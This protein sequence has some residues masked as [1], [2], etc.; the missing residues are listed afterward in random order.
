MVRLSDQIERLRVIN[1]LRITLVMMLCIALAVLLDMQTGVFVIFPVLVISFMMHDES[2]AAGLSLVVGSALGAVISY[3]T[4][5]YFLTARPL[6]LLVTLVVT[7]VL[8]YWAA[9]GFRNRWPWGFGALFAILN[10]AGAAFAAIG[11]AELGERLAFHWMLET[12]LGVAVTWVVMLG[13]WP[14][15]KSGDLVA[16]CEGIEHECAVLLN[17]T[18][19]RIEAEQPISYYPS[20]VSLMNFGKWLGQVDRLKWRF[21]ADR[22][23]HHA[24]RLRMRNL[25]LS[26]VNVRH[27]ERTLEDFPRSESLIEIRA[28]M[29]TILR[30]LA[31]GLEEPGD[32][33]GLDASLALIDREQQERSQNLNE[34]DGE[35]RRI[36][37]K[38]AA[39]LAAARE[40]QHDILTLANPQLSDERIPADASSPENKG[41]IVEDSAKA[42]L[43]LS[44]GVA[45][46]LM[47]HLV[48]LVPAGAYLVLGLVIVMV[49][50]NLGKSHL[51]VRLWFPGVIAGSAYSLLGLLL[52]SLAPHLPLL[53]A[54]LALGFLIGSY[55]GAG[56]DR[57]SYSG[58]QICVGIAVILGMAAFPVA[59]VVTA[60]ERVLGA[61]LG[62]AVALMVGQNFWPEHPANLLRKSFADYLRELPPALSRISGADDPEAALLN[63]H[64]LRLK[65]DVEKDFALLYD[66]SY[67]MPGKAGANYNFH[68]ITH[69]TGNMFHQLW[70]L[71]QILSRVDDIDIRRAMIAPTANAMEQ[72]RNLAEALA[73]TI[74]EGA[75]ASDGVVHARL[76]ELDAAITASEL[77]PTEEGDMRRAWYFGVNFIREMRHQLALVVTSVEGSDR[78]GSPQ[79]ALLAKTYEGAT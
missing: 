68:G 22:Q 57:V 72:V 64:L 41:W 61:I 2:P 48:P 46:A 29:A 21:T 59:T 24:I 67:M 32:T 60:E 23:E 58:F 65:M 6:F 43:K 73:D 79:T 8:G 33:S 71:H 75:T 20:P 13:L 45:V 76:A 38:L 53:L 66:Y 52:I 47:F 18:A 17:K 1:A 49:Q 19:E 40:L 25:M 16:L 10:V 4:I 62:F 27:L 63:S 12:S 51:R 34:P 3:I 36:P 30:G 56:H 50:P 54:W 35:F 42:A 26:Y 11:G 44:L 77:Q 31:D 14:S 74:A 37:A 28:A 69:A 7:C 9:Q 70:T 5:D 15:P 39:F 78:H 55:I